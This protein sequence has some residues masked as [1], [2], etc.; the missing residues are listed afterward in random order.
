MWTTWTKA[1]RSYVESQMVPR[2]M[3]LFSLYVC[4]YI[5]VWFVSKYGERLTGTKSKIV[6]LCKYSIIRYF[7]SVV[8]VFWNFLF[9]A[10]GPWVIETKENKTTYKGVNCVSNFVVWIN[11]ARIELETDGLFV[12]CLPVPGPVL[13]LSVSVR[14]DP[15]HCMPGLTSLCHPVF[16]RVRHWEERGWQGGPHVFLQRPFSLAGF[17]YTPCSVEVHCPLGYTLARP[18]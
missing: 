17:G 7:K 8:I 16:P 10:F 4:V 5:I 11:V 15:A 12:Y 14:A 13:S 1:P 9:N 6:H 18:W 2:S 3:C